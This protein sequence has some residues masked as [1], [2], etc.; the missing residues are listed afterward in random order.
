VDICTAESLCEP[1]QFAIRVDRLGEDYFIVVPTD[2]SSSTRR[3][4]FGDSRERRIVWRGHVHFHFVADR[5]RRVRAGA[6]QE[7]AR[8]TEM[9]GAVL[10][11]WLTNN[12]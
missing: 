5:Q 11:R 4:D 3:R 9:S 10:G 1:Q 6:L 7:R 2:R 12:K 8:P